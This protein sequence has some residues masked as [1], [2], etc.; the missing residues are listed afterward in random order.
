M[1]FLNI[2]DKLLRVLFGAV[3][4][5]AL[6]GCD[7]EARDQLVVDAPI[8][9]DTQENENSRQLA[10][11]VWKLSDSALMV[12]FSHDSKG[13]AAHWVDSHGEVDLSGLLGEAETESLRNQENRDATQQAKLDTHRR[14]EDALDASQ[15]PSVAFDMIAV[16]DDALLQS[17]YGKLVFVQYMQMEPGGRRARFLTDINPVAWVKATEDR[18]WWGRVKQWLGFGG[19]SV[20]PNRAYQAGFRDKDL[21]RAQVG[22]SGGGGEILSIVGKYGAALFDAGD[23]YWGDKTHNKLFERTSLEVPRSSRDSERIAAIARYLN[24]PAVQQATPAQGPVSESAP[25]PQPDTADAESSGFASQSVEIS[26]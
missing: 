10:G 20:H 17:R 13:Y 1:S 12:W 23:W 21:P 14:A 3:L 5:A 25:A 6:C 24:G 18:P 15:L 11:G 8:P 4:V 22:F 26:K 16:G 7:E 19:F 2:P 9:V